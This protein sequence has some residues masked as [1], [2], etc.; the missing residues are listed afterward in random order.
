MTA[1]EKTINQPRGMRAFTIVWVGQ[2]VSLMGTAMTNFAI[3]IY[4]FTETQRVQEL[5][6]LGMAFMIPL[7]VMSPFAGAIV[8]RSNRKLMMMISDLAAGAMTILV[9]ILF[10]TGR[11]EIWQLYIT[12][13]VSGA[14]QAFQWPAYSAAISVMLPKKQYGRA[15][16]LLSLAES[17]STIAAPL[18]AGALLGFIGLRG[19]LFLDIATFSIAIFT[20]LLVHIP[21][22]PRTAE[23]AAGQGNLLH[24]AWYGFQYILDRRSLLGLQ[25]VFMA[26]NFLASIAFVALPALILFRSDNNEVILG[27]VQSI[28]GIGGVIGALVMSAWGGPKKLVHGV[29]IGW[30]LSSLFGTVLF[31][32]GQSLVIWAIAAFISLFFMPII[33]GSNQAIWQAKVAP[34]VQGRVFSARR[35]IAWATNPLAALIAIP[36]ADNIFGPAFETGGSLSETALAT[37][38]GTGPGAGIS[39]MFIITGLLAALVGLAGYLFPAIRNVEELLPD[40]VAADG[41]VEPSATPDELLAVEETKAETR[42]VPAS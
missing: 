23:G 20:L 5:A 34:D 42:P 7:I 6:L 37:V 12:A 21:Q 27:T 13:A 18:L 24:E 1:E 22:P 39:L 31:G 26:G 32:L 11:L 4:I 30:F 17:G 28:G 38:V 14:F 29:L 25:L 19:I 15:N 3:P 35:L 41:D 10:S 33:N 9:L 40:H 2:F 8:D 36:L 16:G